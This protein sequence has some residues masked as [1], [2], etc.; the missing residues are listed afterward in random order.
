MLGQLDEIE[1]GKEKETFY[2]DVIPDTD[3]GYF[4]DFTKETIKS[5]LNVTSIS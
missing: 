4:F 5:I 2:N 1:D 3:S